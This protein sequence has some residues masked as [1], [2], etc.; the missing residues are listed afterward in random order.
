[1][2]LP[3]YCGIDLIHKICDGIP[4]WP[5]ANGYQLKISDSNFSFVD[6]PHGCGTHIDA[7]RHFYED[8]MDVASISLESL[9]GNACI[10]DITKQCDADV[11]YLATKKDILNWE[12]EHGNISANSLFFV[13][14][15]W[16]KYWP[17]ANEYLNFDSIGTMH[18]PGISLDAAEYLFLKG[19]KGIGIDTMSVDGGCSKDFPVHKFTLSRDCFH[20]ENLKDLHLLP[21]KD[22]FVMAMPIRVK[23][24]GEAP[25]RVIGFYK[26]EE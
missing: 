23:E 17:N 6:M 20:V 2:M 19:V 9:T 15:G 10:L 11:D 8:G 3:G 7:P 24:A 5:S 25:A 16:S 26:K 22:A 1:M 21:A 18:F 4:V 14:T 13:Y 12:K